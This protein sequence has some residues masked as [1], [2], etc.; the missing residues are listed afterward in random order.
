MEGMRS[1][2]KGLV[3]KAYQRT[4]DMA[5]KAPD[6]YRGKRK[7]DR[8][9][10]IDREERLRY[11]RGELPEEASHCDPFPEKIRSKRT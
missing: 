5:Y 7:R 4:P 2:R 3:V 11:Y 10:V 6:Y 8:S 1:I 9:I